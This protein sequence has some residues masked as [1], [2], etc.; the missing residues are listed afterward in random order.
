MEENV[1]EPIALGVGWR[2]WRGPYGGADGMI[3]VKL[4]I[5][6]TMRWLRYMG[7]LKNFSPS[8]HPSHVSFVKTIKVEY[9][10]LVNSS[11][12]QLKGHFFLSTQCTEMKGASSTS[13]ERIH[14]PLIKVGDVGFEFLKEFDDGWLNGRVAKICPNAKG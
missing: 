11:K 2:G 4:Q 1:Q 8:A 6:Q 12:D 3:G 14:G 5:E 13:N 9:C 10:R 7:E